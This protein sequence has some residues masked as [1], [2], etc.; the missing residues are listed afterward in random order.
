D[1]GGP[2]QEQ[3]VVEG[4]A[5]PR[6]LG[7]VL[8]RGVRGGGHVGGHLLTRSGECPSC[9]PRGFVPPAAR[10]V[11]WLTGPTVGCRDPGYLS[12]PRIPSRIGAQVG[13]RISSIGRSG[14]G[15]SFCSARSATLSFACFRSSL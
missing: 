12:P 1:V 7:R 13:A 2:G 6:E 5:Q 11:P 15:S 4:E 8:R 10:G 14:S 9:Y 3:D